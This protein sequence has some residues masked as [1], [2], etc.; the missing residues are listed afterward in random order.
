M[1]HYG[2]RGIALSWFKSYLSNR[3]QYTYLNG[4]SSNV[5][6]INC[7]VP[8]GSVLGPLLFLIYINDLPNISKKLTFF[9]FADDTNIFYESKSELHLEKTVNKELKKLYTWLVVNRLALNIDKT[10]FIIFHPYNKPKKQN[11]NLR[12]N[13][14]PINRAN[15][16]K[17][18]GI[19]LDSTLSWI[20]HI[21]KISNKMKRALGLM[22]KIRPYVFSKTLLT[23]Y[24]S[25]IYPH[26]IYG[27][28]VWGS[29]NNSLLNRLITL[30]KRAVRVITFKDKRQTDYSF[31]ASNPLFIKLK[32]LKV[33]CI[34]KMYISRFVFK[35]LKKIC[36]QHFWFAT[37]GLQQQ[38]IFTPTSQ[39]L[40][41][42]ITFISLV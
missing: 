19:I 12:I 16:I 26:I 34:F 10:K 31:P 28:E 33:Y 25:L 21:D 41:Q 13:K 22:Y 5:K 1:E 40:A 7:G 15:N 9:L 20:D 39:D 24:Y 42:I 18:L 29:C 32:I 2:I 36:M 38:L 8:Q 14:K 3:K 4:I 6:Q 37:L 11:I 27:I 35:Y 17:Y 30:Q 23:L